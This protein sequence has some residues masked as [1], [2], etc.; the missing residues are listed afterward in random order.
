MTTE[1]GG[2]LDG[3]WLFDWENP[4][5]E[6]AIREMLEDPINIVVS[7][8][9]PSTTG[10]SST[11]H[12]RIVALAETAMN[13]ARSLLVPGGIFV[14]KVWQGGSEQKLLTDLK[15][16]FEQVHHF[17]PEASRSE[18]TEMYVIARGYRGKIK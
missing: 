11:D 3:W 18:S 15:Q 9:S 6:K 8:M 16:D 12:I 1:Y 10:H 14:T 2:D 5:P 7:D 4:S 13:L 17:K